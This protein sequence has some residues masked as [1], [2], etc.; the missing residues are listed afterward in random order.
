MPEIA[1]P[2]RLPVTIV[3]G[4][5]GSGKTTLV[6]Q[7]LADPRGLRTAV[8]VNEF[9][10]L[11]IDSELIEGAAETGGV[12]ELANG[13]IC[14]A[15]ND[16]LAAVALKLARRRPPIDRL[17]V[18]LSGLADPLPV[19][20]TFLRPEL[21]PALRLDAVVALADAENFAVSGV[22]GRIAL[23]QL[24]HA[25][26]VLV[27]KCD[28]AGP[29]RVAETERRIWAAQPTVRL[30]R[31]TRSA[32]PPAL[33]SGID[34]A[35][36][37]AAPAAPPRRG[38]AARDRCAAV[39]FASTRPLDLD[40]FQS[41]LEALPANVLRANGILWLDRDERRWIF[42]LVGT[43]FTLDQSRWQGSRSNRL[44]L[45]GQ[46]LDAERLRDRLARCLVAAAG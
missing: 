2:A 11:A 44:V 6:N 12:I 27:N 24:R 46:E 39:S 37:D 33:I 43:R 35:E 30:V 36:F 18:E 8:L 19:A 3:A 38:H 23:E 41:F 45:I 22:V 15:L 16:D 9:G 26:L 4:F 31:T 25:D 13:C 14:C 42:H 29:G 5:L 10:G 21:R 32:V 7:L 17:I 28:L 20:L 40:R 34:R 1:R